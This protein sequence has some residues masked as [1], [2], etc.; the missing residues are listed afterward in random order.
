M[1]LLGQERSTENAALAVESRCDPI[2][3]V[4]TKAN[5]SRVSGS[6]NRHAGA[7]RA[8]TER[9][10]GGRAENCILKAQIKRR[11]LLSQ[12]EKATLGTVKQ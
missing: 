12:E 8:V 6:Y 9:L 7:A 5:S 2:V 11:L 4:A 3:L 10:S 1:L